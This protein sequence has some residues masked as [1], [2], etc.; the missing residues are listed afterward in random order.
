MR[1][2]AGWLAQK[3]LNSF[4]VSNF[5][6]AG[7]PFKWRPATGPKQWRETA[8]PEMYEIGIAGFAWT[9]K[10]I[11]RTM[12]YNVNVPISDTHVDICL[13]NCAPE[14]YSPRI[15]SSPAAYLALGELKG[16]IDPAG[17][18]EHWKTARSALS[19]IN[20]SF[21]GAQ[22]SPHTFFIGGAIETKMAAEI[23]EMLE[24]GVIE[25]AANLTSDTQLNS[26][27][28]WLIRI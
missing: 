10:R 22:A 23:W 4:I 3:R 7:I 5:D 20:A 13:F 25:N 9:I 28:N 16:G 6:N 17:A 18:D 1:N 19:R 12:I 11:Q 24:S 21:S 15:L 14:N 8:G 26:L 27:V 2:V